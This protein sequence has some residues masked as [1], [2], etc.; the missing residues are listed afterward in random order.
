MIWNPSTV[1]VR[2]IE[3]SSQ[4]ITARI[5]RQNYSD[6]VLFAVYASPNNSKRNELWQDLETLSQTMDAPWLLAGDF[7][8]FAIQSKKRSLSGTQSQSQSQDQRRSRKFIVRMNSC[9]LMELG[10][11]GPRL[12]WT[13]NRQ[14]WANTM[15]FILAS[16]ETPS[17]TMTW[18]L[19]LLLNHNQALKLVQEELDTHVGRQRWAWS[20]LLAADLCCF[21]SCFCLDLPRKESNTSDQHTE[22][23]Q[24]LTGTMVPGIK[25]GRR[26]RP[27]SGNVLSASEACPQEIGTHRRFSMRRNHR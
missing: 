3:A 20:E 14:R 23:V 9:N 15:L 12:T 6:W 2:V 22:W 26:K 19:S 18:A 10:C 17:I 11:T 24:H 5:S 1:N 4:L 13:N 8:D 27:T 7:N 21:S 16:F 25:T